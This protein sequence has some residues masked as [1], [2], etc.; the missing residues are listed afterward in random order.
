MVIFQQNATIQGSGEI[1]ARGEAASRACIFMYMQHDST[2]VFGVPIPSQHLKALGSATQGHARDRDSR[3][4]LV[5][6]PQDKRQLQQTYSG[7]SA[8]V[9]TRPKSQAAPPYNS[10][11]QDDCHLPAMTRLTGGYALLGPVNKTYRHE[12]V[13]SRKR[14]RGGGGSVLL[15]TLLGEKCTIVSILPL[16]DIWDL[17]GKV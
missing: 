12:R 9:A 4:A 8:R 10:I 7:R 14:Q 11:F 16:Q 2:T 17:A 15:L 1:H 13:C 6:N 5:G 3:A